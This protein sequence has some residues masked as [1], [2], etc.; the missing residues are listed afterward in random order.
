MT[1]LIKEYNALAVALEEAKAVP[2]KDD[3]M[4][5]LIKLQSDHLEI[6]TNLQF[7]H[8]IVRHHQE[9]L[10]HATN[11]MYTPALTF[12]PCNKIYAADVLSRYIIAVKSGWE[13]LHAERIVVNL[14]NKA[15]EKRKYVTS[16]KMDKFTNIDYS[17]LLDSLVAIGFLDWHWVR[18]CELNAPS[19]MEAR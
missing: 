16:L 10:D 14:L 4:M 2:E 3:T 15:V 18:D 13:T 6:T 12:L 19:V 5:R 1:I 17:A 11:L 8:E 7:A 9:T